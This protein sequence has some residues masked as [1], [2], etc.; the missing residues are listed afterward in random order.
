MRRFRQAAVWANRYQL[1]LGLV[2][3]APLV[4]WCYW[5][6]ADPTGAAGA[7]STHLPQERDPATDYW[8]EVCREFRGQRSDYVWKFG[9]QD[10]HQWDW[11]CSA[12]KSR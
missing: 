1:E 5:T 12:Y 2:V 11:Q 7:S 9:A 10:A 3:M 8:R 4:L 6:P